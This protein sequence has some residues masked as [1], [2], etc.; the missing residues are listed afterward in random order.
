VIPVCEPL[1]TAEDR[2][3]VDDAVASGWIS[4]AGSYLD[5]FEASWAEVCGRRHG[6]AVANG[7]VA[8]QL[9]VSALGL[10]PRSE[11]VM[12]SFTIISC[13]LAAL[14]NDCTPV[15]VDADPS[16]WCMDIEQ[17]AA[18]TTAAAAAIMP[19]HTYGHPVDM[20]PLLDLAADRDLRIVEDAAEAHGARYLSRRGGPDEW[21]YCGGFGELSA[22][23]FYANK[24]VTTGEGGMVLTD[25]DR[26]AEEARSRRNLCFQPKRRFLHEEL[27]HNFRMTNL[28]AA[29]GVGQ[30]DRLE[31]IVA[32]KRRIAAMYSERL[33]A[34][35]RLELPPEASWARSVFWVYGVVLHDSLPVD[36]DEMGRRLRDRGVD[37]RPFFLGMHEQPVLAEFV[38][39]KRRFPVTERLSRRGFYLPNGLT[40]TESQIDEACDALRASLP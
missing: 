12:P 38:A 32:G 11:V 24:L 13:A 35:D 21:H 18:A 33:A 25:D 31:D 1:I 29:L 40:I 27:G 30:I 15:F 37:T 39:D 34:D 19:V 3:N 22:F 4:S 5:R 8:L 17:T 7:T 23:S 28:Q 26:L 10:P 16:T 6:I 36:A 9:A 2:R 20:D 14:Y